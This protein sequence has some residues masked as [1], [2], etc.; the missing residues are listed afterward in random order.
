MD[1]VRQACQSGNA[2]AVRGFIAQHG[3]NIVHVRLDDRGQTLLHHAGNMETAQVLVNH[4]GDVNMQDNR[5]V[6]PLHKA[7]G[8]GNL[9]LVQY[10]VG[11]GASVQVMDEGCLLPVDYAFE[12]DHA[13]IADYLEGLN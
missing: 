6:T 10:L 11:V 13:E 1:L 5:S 12:N 7:C 9:S 3:Q 2:V 8:R 4:G